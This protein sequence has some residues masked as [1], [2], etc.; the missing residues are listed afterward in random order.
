MVRGGE[1]WLEP[2]LAIDQNLKNRPYAKFRTYVNLD[3][4]DKN[5]CIH[6]LNTPLCRIYP[7]P[8]PPPPEN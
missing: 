3:K 1:G 8:P 7:P 4:Y 2:H 5:L 6:T